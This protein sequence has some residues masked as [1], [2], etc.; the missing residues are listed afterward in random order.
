MIVPALLGFWKT[1][2]KA[3]VT[4]GKAKTY[5]YEMLFQYGR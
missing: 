2:L 3:S 4:L 1:I 5:F